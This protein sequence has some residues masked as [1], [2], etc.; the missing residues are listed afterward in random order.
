MMTTV[1]LR[2]QVN[3]EWNTDL[4]ETMKLENRISQTAQCLYGGNESS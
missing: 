3:L 4:V 2:E 1:K